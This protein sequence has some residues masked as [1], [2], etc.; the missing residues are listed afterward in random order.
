MAKSVWYICLE[1]VDVPSYT[2]T[3]PLLS[4]NFIIKL[5]SFLLQGLRIQTISKEM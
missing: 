1:E 2:W 4:L 5:F 3:P